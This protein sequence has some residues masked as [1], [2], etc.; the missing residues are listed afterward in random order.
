MG[1]SVVARKITSVLLFSLL[2][3]SLA[4]F[5]GK[6]GLALLFGSAITMWLLFNAYRV[7]PSHLRFLGALLISSALYVFVLTSLLPFFRSFAWVDELITETTAAQG[8]DYVEIPN[9]EVVAIVPWSIIAS[10]IVVTSLAWPLLRLLNRDNGSSVMLGQ[11]ITRRVVTTASES[12]RSAV[13]YLTLVPLIA[14]ASLHARDSVQSIAFTM[15][16][17]GRN[18]FLG[19]MRMRLA[20]AFPGTDH[21]VKNG[22]FGEVLS[23]G[24]AITN[25]VR[26]FP[27]IQDQYAI[28]SVYVLSLCL[29][30][31]SLGA[32]IM[33]LTKKLSQRIQIVWF[34]ISAFLAVFVLVN[35][36]PIAEMLRSGFFSMFVALGFL[37][38]TVAVIVAQDNRQTECVVLLILGSILT[39]AS[40][41]LFAAV[42]LP[43][44]LVMVLW[45]SWHFRH[46]KLWRSCW[47][48]A[49]GAIIWLAVAENQNLYAEFKLRVTDGGAIE[50]TS[51]A[52]TVGLCLLSALLISLR[53]LRPLAAASFV[54]SA[55][56]I[57][58]LQLIV[59]AR[60]ELANAYGYYGHKLIYAANYVSALMALALMIAIVCML[61]SKFV[62]LDKR[63]GR[64]IG[65]SVIA[66]L[67]VAVLPAAVLLGFNVPTA[68]SQVENVLDGWNA[69][70]ETTVRDM[71]DLWNNGDT[72]YI[73]AQLNSDANDRIANF[74][75][76]YFWERNRWEWTYSG[77]RTDVEGLCNIIGGN[78]VL[79]VTSS[80]SLVRQMRGYC[81]TSTAQLQVR[82]L[83]R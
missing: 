74:W 12:Y 62:V 61:H 8:T 54:I 83:T 58:T 44:V 64:N 2:T 45:T 21:I 78:S 56:S 46:S 52:F 34:L 17:D 68:D 3:M 6:A 47:F 20:N 77:Y 24:I 36:Y 13:H 14:I 63:I 49:L 66:I 28:R 73:V 18:F 59:V 51:I 76:P 81:P 42:L 43:V 72:N 10:M 50:G 69:P 11:R 35:P 25:N 38:A 30:C 48:A 29:I 4:Y 19:V 33:T 40:Y 27:N 82:Y 37:I 41:Q 80:E 71:L 57:A 75:S 65:L 1:N 39:Y 55:S 22:M 70:S 67:T 7:F 32:I 23:T 16:G 5:V 15:S 26:M 31:V 60:G 53:P 79:L 9:G